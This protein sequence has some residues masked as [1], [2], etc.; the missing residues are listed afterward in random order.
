M[1]TLECAKNAAA[2]ISAR[3]FVPGWMLRDYLEMFSKQMYEDDGRSKCLLHRIGADPVAVG[4]RIANEHAYETY[5]LLGSE[6]VPYEMDFYAI[7][8]RK[9][10][11]RKGI[12]T[13][14]L[15]RLSCD[16][17][18]I[19]VCAPGIIGSE[20]FWDNHNVKRLWE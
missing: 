16:S 10:H 9:E 2:A 15:R 1:A 20:E 5:E 12:A 18:R 11:R 6:H 7:F 4:I 3:L 13:S 17:Y 8:V 14:L 19:R